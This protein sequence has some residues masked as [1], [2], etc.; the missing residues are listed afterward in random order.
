MHA[1]CHTRP[2]QPAC[3]ESVVVPV[4]VLLLLLL[5]LLRL[6]LLVLLLVLLLAVV[7][8]LDRRRRGARKLDGV[9][10]ARGADGVAADGGQRHGE[11]HAQQHVDGHGWARL[12]FVFGLLQRL[13][14]RQRQG[15]PRHRDDFARPRRLCEQ[16]QRG[17]KRPQWRCEAGLCGASLGPPAALL[18]LRPADGFLALRHNHLLRARDGLV[19]GA[20]RLRLAPLGAPRRKHHERRGAG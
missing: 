7:E 18:A 3:R 6:V 1:S 13:L 16:Q 14:H 10:L 5:L 2:V 12:R 9:A 15:R 8:A 17:A 19:L 11:Q 4:L 20:R